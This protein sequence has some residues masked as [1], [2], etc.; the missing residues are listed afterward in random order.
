MG[1]VA[2]VA[3]SAQAGAAG[4]A[5]TYLRT[6]G[7]PS[8]AMMYPSGLDVDASGNAYIADTGND[9]VV[10]FGPSGSRL[11]RVGVRGTKA[12]GRF[13]NPRDI[14]YIAGQLYVAD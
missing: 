13:S 7:H 14:A 6:I 11:W 9:Q 2:V 4:I 12:P 3:T 10:A 8:H 5:P 1:V